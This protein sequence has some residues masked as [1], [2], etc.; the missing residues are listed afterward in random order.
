MASGL[1]C[2][3]DIMIM[4]LIG[5]SMRQAAAGHQESGI[6]FNN[7]WFVLS[8]YTVTLLFC[9][10]Y[11]QYFMIHKLPVL[12]DPDGVLSS[13]DATKGGTQFGLTEAQRGVW[14]MS[15]LCE[16]GSPKNDKEEEFDLQIVGGDKN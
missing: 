11:C 13:G 6:S 7:P 14:P 9:F 8:L 10:V 16:N 3:Y 2:Q 1:G 15:F 12:L 5:Q 4:W